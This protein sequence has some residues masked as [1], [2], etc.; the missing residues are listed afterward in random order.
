MITDRRAIVK[1]LIYLET[2]NQIR[3]VTEAQWDRMNMSHSVFSVARIR[4]GAGEGQ[5]S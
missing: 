1:S 5:G 2:V 4:G 3:L